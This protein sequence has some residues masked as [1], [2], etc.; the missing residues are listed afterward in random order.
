ME[1][2][3]ICQSC[4]VPMSGHG[5]NADGSQ[6]DDY[7]CYCFEKGSFKDS[8]KTVE[9]MINFCAPLLARD[10]VFPD[11]ETARKHLQKHLPP[12]K[13]WKAA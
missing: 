5:T 3:K 11:E 7:C 8:N 10:G 9:E 1:K 2:A 12:L 4:G 6:S 13:R